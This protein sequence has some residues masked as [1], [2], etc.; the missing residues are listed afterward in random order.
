MIRG[1]RLEASLTLGKGSGLEIEFNHVAN[2]LINHTHELRSQ[3]KSWT[4]KLVGASCLA[5]T[6]MWWGRDV[7]WFHGQRAWRLCFLDSPSIFPICLFTWLFLNCILYTIIISIE[8]SWVLW[9]IP[10]NCQISRGHGNSRII[11][12]LSEVWVAWEQRLSLVSEVRIVLLELCSLTC[13][14]STNSGW[15]VLSE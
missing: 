6:S 3:Y 5:N 10:A 11:A 14:V 2:D 15:L 13:G 9:V 12:F 7:S 4:L 1:L 8:P